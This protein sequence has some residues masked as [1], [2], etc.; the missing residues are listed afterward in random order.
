MALHCIAD[1]ICTEEIILYYL[2]TTVNSL[3][4]LSLYL[5]SSFRLITET[6]CF[7]SNVRRPPTN[8]HLDGPWKL[9]AVAII[10]EY[11]VGIHEPNYSLA[12]WGAQLCCL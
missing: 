2:I 11:L 9:T 3:I 4:S 7:I 5:L 8:L 10:R 6:P 1:S 12:R